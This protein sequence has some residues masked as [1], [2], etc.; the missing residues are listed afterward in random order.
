MRFG[1]AEERIRARL[2]S[3]R[4]ASSAPRE[5]GG[6]T[7]ESQQP[8]APRATD[9]T[10]PMDAAERELL[11]VILQ[12]PACL[13]KLREEFSLEQLSSPQAR[14]ILSRCSQW[15]EGDVTLLDWLLTE[16][17][18]PDMKSLLVDLDERGRAKGTANITVRFELILPKLQ[19]LPFEAEQR[20]RASQ[21]KEQTLDENSQ[22]EV[23]KKLFA[24]ER[25]RHGI[26]VP[27]DGSEPC[28]LVDDVTDDAASASTR[29]RQP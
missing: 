29:T 6:R 20:R 13:E 8:A 23:F 2:T 5:R 16:F 25:S 19:A 7:A 27:T 28:R 15:S 11:E 4:R 21:L 12:A 14:A 1:L 22:M 26:S 10:P 9:R 17:D 18:E 3:L 24:G